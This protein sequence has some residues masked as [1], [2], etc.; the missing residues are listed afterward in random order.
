MRENIAIIISILALIVAT[1][2]CYLTWRQAKAAEKERF[3][4][5]PHNAYTAKLDNISRALYHAANEIKTLSQYK[6]R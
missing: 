1:L 4:D 2:S 6:D 3:D 5:K